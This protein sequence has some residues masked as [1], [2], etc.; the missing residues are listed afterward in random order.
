MRTSEE[1]MKEEE[2]L[3]ASFKKTLAAIR[4][5]RVKLSQSQYEASL[6]QLK[7]SLISNGI[8]GEIVVN[9][10]GSIIGMK[11][12]GR[13]YGFMERKGGYH[14]WCIPA[15]DTY[16][17]LCDPPDITDISVIVNLIDDA[18]LFIRT[19]KLFDMEAYMEMTERFTPRKFLSLYEI[20]MYLTFRGA[21]YTEITSPI[22]QSFPLKRVRIMAKYDYQPQRHYDFELATNGY[23]YET[24]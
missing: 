19:Y 15:D 17:F 14:C 4:E 8:E 5:E 24:Y 2:R 23:W 21:I 6:D 10:V 16:G 13:F 20:I 7:V 22:T 3:T 1:L 12:N 11:I 18:Y 9:D